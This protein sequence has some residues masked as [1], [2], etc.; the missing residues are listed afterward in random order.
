MANL[1]NQIIAGEA[2][3]SQDGQTVTLPLPKIFTDCAPHL[4][5]AEKLTEILTSHNILLETFHSAFKD[6]FVS[7]RDHNR[8]KEDGK[9]VI[10]VTPE[11]SLMWLPKRQDVPQTKT[12]QDKSEIGIEILMTLAK[13]GYDLNDLATKSHEQLES[14][15]KDENI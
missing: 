8:L 6:W 7:W 13:R 4:Q 2:E 1:H 5:D 11:H 10:D 3:V 9:S 14:I 15:L 12:R